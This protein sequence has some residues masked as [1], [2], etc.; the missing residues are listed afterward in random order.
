MPAVAA[1][2]G[3]GVIDEIEKQ[4]CLTEEYVEPSRATLYRYGNVSS[5]SIW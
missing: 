5:S 3:R 1:A 2:G 4:L